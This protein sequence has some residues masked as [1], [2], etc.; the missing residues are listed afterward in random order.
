MFAKIKRLLGIKP[1][2]DKQA[3]PFLKFDREM[4]RLL[5][6][7]RRDRLAR[8]LEQCQTEYVERGFGFGNKNDA[9][10]HGRL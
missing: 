8:Q 5:R 7:A 2:P 10:R 4:E 9:D 3:E 6:E 1:S